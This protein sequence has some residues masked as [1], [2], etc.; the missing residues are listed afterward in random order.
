MLNKNINNKFNIKIIKYNDFY[1]Y[2]N[3]NNMNTQ[4][5]FNLLNFNNKIKEKFIKNIN[6]K[7][8]FI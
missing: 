8:G 1:A 4:Y 2:P 5:I 6:K 7:N 3:K